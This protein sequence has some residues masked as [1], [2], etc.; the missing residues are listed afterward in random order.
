M[1]PV[2]P[3][4]TTLAVSAGAALCRTLTAAVLV[5]PLLLVTVASLPALAV[6]PFLR[7]GEL[8]TERLLRQL[9]GWT[10]V[11]TLRRHP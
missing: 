9:V 4:F 10:R 11:L 6:L 2:P 3:L 5:L 1:T 8:R 7:D